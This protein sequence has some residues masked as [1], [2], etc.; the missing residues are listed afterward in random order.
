MSLS[1]N[2]LDNCMIDRY[3][4][5]DIKMKEMLNNKIYNIYDYE[6][7]YE[8]CSEEWY[9][10]FINMRIRDKKIEGYNPN[11]TE[12][13]IL[14]LQTE[15]NF[16]NYFK[17][18]LKLK[19]KTDYYVKIENE[20]V[21]NSREKTDDGSL[22]LPKIDSNLRKENSKYT[23]SLGKSCDNM[24]ILIEEYLNFIEDMNSEFSFKEFLELKTY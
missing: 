21:N 15:E 16:I 12:N 22:G 23:T 18:F 9:N 20:I 13:S 5:L 4:K 8:D 14:F 24:Y 3:N 10:K 1:N 7:I 19:I 2:E 6:T 17:E 11:L